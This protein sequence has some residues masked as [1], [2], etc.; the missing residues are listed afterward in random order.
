MKRK[1]RLVEGGKLA[2]PS[3]FADLEALRIPD[4]DPAGVDNDLPRRKRRGRKPHMPQI[5]GEFVPVLPERLWDRQYD[6]VYPP[7][8]RLYLFIVM[9]SRR[10]LEPFPL[11]NDMTA[12]L[13][14]SGHHKTEYLKELE[15]HGLVV[16]T[17]RG[18]ATV[19]VSAEG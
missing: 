8:T 12:N 17:R 13:A 2:K 9:R 10:G 18:R 15:Q 5:E 3:I 19:V 14:I 11:T 6:F 7:R 1:F 4:D 16:V